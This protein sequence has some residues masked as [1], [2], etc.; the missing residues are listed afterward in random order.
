MSASLTH[1][2]KILDVSIL[3]AHMSVNVTQAAQVTPNLAANV[4]QLLLSML[5]NERDVELMHNVDPEVVLLNASAPKH[6]QMVIQPLVA[7]TR[8]SVSLYV[9]DNSRYFYMPLIC[10]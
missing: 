7:Q 8:K 4:H 3:L 5:A 1:V 10:K 6:I 2:V 9:I